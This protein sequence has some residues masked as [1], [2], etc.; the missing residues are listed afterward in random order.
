MNVICALC[1]RLQGSP[2]KNKSSTSAIWKQAVKS[3]LKALLLSEMTP[4]SEMSHSSAPKD[5]SLEEE[6]R[7]L[8]SLRFVN[9]FPLS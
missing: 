7:R 2:S 5:R 4:I 9:V 3:R 1:C 6:G 8:I